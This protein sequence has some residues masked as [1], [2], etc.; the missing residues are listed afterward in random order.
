[1]YSTLCAVYSCGAG[2]QCDQVSAEYSTY[3]YI[4]KN[5]QSRVE[6]YFTV[7]KKLPDK[8]EQEETTFLYS[9]TSDRT[10]T[11]EKFQHISH[12]TRL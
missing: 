1:M 8:P 7:H 11:E 5:A 2:R 10:E 9:S 3:P 4:P 12:A 6:T